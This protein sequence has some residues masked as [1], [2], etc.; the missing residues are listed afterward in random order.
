MLRANEMLCYPVAEQLAYA[1]A[2]KDRICFMMKVFPT[3]R[4]DT[5]VVHCSNLMQPVLTPSYL[6]MPLAEL[7]EVREENHFCDKCMDHGMHRFF[8]VAATVIEEDGKRT[9]HRA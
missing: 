7:H 4:W 8:D 3:V 1:Q 6:D 5:S 9:V 2:N